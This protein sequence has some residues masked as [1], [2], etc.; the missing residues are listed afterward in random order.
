LH[1]IELNED[2]K[3][4]E[5]EVSLLNGEVK[6]LSKQVNTLTINYDALLK[7][8]AEIKANLK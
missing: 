5:N 3:A 2:K 7:E 1:L 4:L 8:L 6:Q